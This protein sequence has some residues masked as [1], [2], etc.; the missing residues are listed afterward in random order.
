[1]NILHEATIRKLAQCDRVVY[2]HADHFEPSSIKYP[3]KIDKILRRMI[4]DIKTGFFKPSLFLELPATLHW[5]K[6][7]SIPVFSAYPFYNTVMSHVK[8]LSDLGC[9]IHMH[10]HHER[11]THSDSTN[12]EWEEPFE[13]RKVSDS[14]LLDFFIVKSLDEFKK[15][16][17]PI[18]D[19][20]FVHGRWGLNASDPR[21]CSI[22]DEIN[23]LNRN[24][25]VADFTMPAGRAKCNPSMSGIYVIKPENKARCYD[26][27]DPV[28]KGSNLL[29]SK[30]AFIMCYPSTNYFYV[31]LDNLI[32][33]AGTTSKTYFHSEVAEDNEKA[34]EDPWIIVQEWLLCSCIV[35][36]TLII[37]T[38]SHNMRFPFWQD[39][40]GQLVNN[41]PIF[42]D[43]QKERIHML[44]GICRERGV[45]FYPI[46]ARELLKFIRWV[47]KGEEAKD[48]VW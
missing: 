35:E 36:R 28:F 44:R 42:N 17:I 12:A 39:E 37:K 4:T 25:C 19:W 15:Y 26:M 13:K 47:D 43:Q 14:E 10:I 29:G 27:G 48:Y 8:S 32:L 3:D 33:K 5:K 24:G 23:I 38:H 16:K 45:D 1:M 41:S 20:C 18:K 7:E 6:D 30:N 11:W 34:P 2:M 40:V 9:D 22:T 21:T 31:S 46:T